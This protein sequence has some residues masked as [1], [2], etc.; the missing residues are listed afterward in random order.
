MTAKSVSSGLYGLLTKHRIA[1][2]CGGVRDVF[3][4]YFFATHATA[5]LESN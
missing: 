1:I 5:T 3:N 4:G 2:F